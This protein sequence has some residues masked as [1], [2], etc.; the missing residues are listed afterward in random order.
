LPQDTTVQYYNDGEYVTLTGPK[1]SIDSLYG[2]YLNNRQEILKSIEQAVPET[3]TEIVN[4]EKSFL[5]VPFLFIVFAAIVLYKL[6]ARLSSSIE[7]NVPDYSDRPPQQPGA[8]FHS[9]GKL[10][11]HGNE[12]EFSDIEL[13]TVLNKHFPYYGKLG[14]ENKERFLYR[15]S[16]FISRKIFVIHDESGFKEMPILI[17]ASAIQLSFGLDKYQL[18]HFSHIHIFP[19]EFIG[20]HPT[21]RLLEG[22]VSGHS[23]NL[24]WKHFLNG[25]QLPDNG[26]NVGLHEF[27]HAFYF[28]YFETGSHVEADFVETF[29][30]FD[31][32]GSKVFAL[33]QQRTDRLYSDYA[34]RNFQEFWAESIEIFFERPADLKQQYEELYGSICDILEQDPLNEKFNHSV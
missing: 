14:I 24:S 12:L 11:Y 30:L 27:A 34:M 17:S 28:Q 32:C 26:Q 33:E 19:E 4:E 23:I 2:E 15:L 20:Y 29:P 25:Y 21:L 13:D 31:A 18:P 9:T 10:T 7:R 1:E 8:A 22:N 16:A 5:Y 6:Q 3:E